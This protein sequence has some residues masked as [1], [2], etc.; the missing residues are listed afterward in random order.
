MTESEA[1]A[2]AWC[3]SYL[4][5]FNDGDVDRISAHWAFPAL[6]LSGGQRYVYKSADQFRR[7]TSGLLSFYSD[8]GVAHA[9]RTCVAVVSFSEDEIA[10]R[11]E[12]RFYGEEGALMAHWQAGYVLQRDAAD[13]RAILASA[14]GEAAAWRAR[15]TPL[16]GT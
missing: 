3:D 10:F 11:A 13:W 16:P 1:I 14:E 4:R 6:I 2:A 9:E 12:D 15:G 5:A 7:N 8:Q